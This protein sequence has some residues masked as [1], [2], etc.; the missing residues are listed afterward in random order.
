[1]GCSQAR[2][3]NVT[4]V[5]PTA[6]IEV[7]QTSMAEVERNPKVG[8]PM[9]NDAL[10]QA[11]KVQNE[12]SELQNDLPTISYQET[13]A[14]VPAIFSLLPKAIQTAGDSPKSMMDA[15]AV[16]EYCVTFCNEYAK[17]GDFPL[18]QGVNP[19]NC[20]AA[21]AVLFNQTANTARKRFHV[22]LEDDAVSSRKMASV[23]KAACALFKLHGHGQQCAEAFTSNHCVE[24]ALSALSETSGLET[25]AKVQIAFMLSSLMDTGHDKATSILSSR[26]WLPMSKCKLCPSESTIASDSKADRHSIWSDSSSSKGSSDSLE[27]LPNTPSN[28][29]SRCPS[30]SNSH[31]PSGSNSFNCSQEEQA[32]H[33]PASSSSCPSFSLDVPQPRGAGPASSGSPSSSF[34]LPWRC[35][36][37]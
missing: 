6:S 12:W 14:M 21:L 22:N 36:S 29:N 16:I 5:V 27:I 13:K 26:Q 18:V 30:G 33:P 31:C 20:Q 23:A 10:Q 1:M 35:H 37:K 19:K 11:P 34:S 17:C 25:T 32:R 8:L 28:S 3:A 9:L 15:C 24:A 4:I 2:S 7:I